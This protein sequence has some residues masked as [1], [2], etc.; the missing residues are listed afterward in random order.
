RPFAVLRQPPVLPWILDAALSGRP[1][2]IFSKSPIPLGIFYAALT[3]RAGTISREAAVTGRILHLAL[4]CRAWTVACK[5]PVPGRIFAAPP[6]AGAHLAARFAALRNARSRCR[7]APSRR[8]GFSFLRRFVSVWL[9]ALACVLVVR[10]VRSALT[11]GPFIAW[12]T[13]GHLIL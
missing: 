10:G 4:A 7:S 6:P 5:P 11:V 1:F 12:R 8:P 2:A 9:P 13:S 3:R